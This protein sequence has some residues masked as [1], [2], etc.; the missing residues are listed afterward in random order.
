MIFNVIT[1]VV[2]IKLDIG[3]WVTPKTYLYILPRIKEYSL[4]LRRPWFRFEYVVKDIKV[5]TLIFKDIG[6]VIYE[7]GK[8]EYNYK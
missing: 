3:G 4:I 7:E 6:I 1:E 8:Y 2:C 5:G